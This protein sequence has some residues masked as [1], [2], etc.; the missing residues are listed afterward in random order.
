MGNNLISYFTRT[1]LDT[2]VEPVEDEATTP[3]PE[4]PEVER[5][6]DKQFVAWEI[7]VSNW[8][9]HGSKGS[10]MKKRRDGRS[11]YLR[12]KDNNTSVGG[13]MEVT[14][15]TKLVKVA[16]PKVKAE[17]KVAQCC[18]DIKEKKVLDLKRW[19]VNRVAG[20]ANMVTCD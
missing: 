20:N 12:E 2:D 17:V 16:L 13:A 4:V 10:K 6:T 1:R 15:K 11:T 19:Y 5:P 3:I 7:D 9:A 18:N 14:S 8:K